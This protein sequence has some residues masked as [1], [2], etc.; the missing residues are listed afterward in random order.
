MNKESCLFV[1]TFIYAMDVKGLGL[2]ETSDGLFELVS[3]Q[4]EEFSKLNKEFTEKNIVAFLTQNFNYINAQL[5]L[6]EP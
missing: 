3:A 4:F 5:N 1:L 2:N 6:L